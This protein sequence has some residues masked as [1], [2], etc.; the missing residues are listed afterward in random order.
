MKRLFDIFLILI[1]LPLLLPLLLIVAVLVR[2][3]LGSPVLFK[4]VRP[5]LNSKNPLP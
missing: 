2:V 5:G 3:K 1:S 4:Q